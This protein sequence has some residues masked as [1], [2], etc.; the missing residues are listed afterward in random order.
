MDGRE[1]GVNYGVEILVPPGGQVNQGNA[2]IEALGIGF[3]AI[4]CDTV[5]AR[6]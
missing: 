1:E 2:A 3:A 6:C 4:D 5:T